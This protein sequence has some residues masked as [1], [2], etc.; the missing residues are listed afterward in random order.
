[1]GFWG[2]KTA[3]KKLILSEVTKKMSKELKYFQNEPYLTPN[4]YDI[5]F[6]ENEIKYNENPPIKYQMKN[7]YVHSASKKVESNNNMDDAPAAPEYFDE[8][9]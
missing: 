6:N 3:L 9:V 5:Y 2:E 7:Y 1:M 8:V 4:N